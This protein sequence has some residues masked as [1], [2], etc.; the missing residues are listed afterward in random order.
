[1]SKIR[2]WPWGW[3][4]SGPLAAQNLQMPHPGTHK[5][6]KCPAVAR[7][8]GGGGGGGAQLELTDP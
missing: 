6:G 3:Q 7:G 4:M 2:V 8:V 5:V 1:M